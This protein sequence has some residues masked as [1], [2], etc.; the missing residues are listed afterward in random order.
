VIDVGGTSVKILATGHSERRSFPSGPKMTPRRM[1]AGVK[2]LARDWS[3]DA[4]S[5]GYPGPVLHAVRS[6]NRTISPAD[7]SGSIS[8]QPSVAR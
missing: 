3:Y 4:V 1:V 7:G 6:L 5:I 8:Q 2:K